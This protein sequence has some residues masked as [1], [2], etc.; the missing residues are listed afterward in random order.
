MAQPTAAASEAATAQQVFVAAYRKGPKY[1][2]AKSL[3]RQTGVT[4]HMAHIRSIAPSVI[5]ASPVEPSGDDLLGYVIFSA[6]DRAAAEAWLKAD[7]AV[8][9]G[10][11]K[12][13]PPPLGA[14][15]ASRLGKVRPRRLHG[16]AAD[17]RGHALAAHRPYRKL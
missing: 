10:S 2:G 5:G 17:P 7:P 11:M 1:D 14:C 12:A 15:L 4:E 3:F 9:A 6:Q 16:R 13:D 8:L